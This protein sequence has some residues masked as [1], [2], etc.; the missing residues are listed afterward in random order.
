MSNNVGSLYYQVLLDGG[1]VEKGSNRIKKD[2]RELTKFLKDQS[3]KQV[4]DVDLLHKRR[5]RLLAAAR[6]L[7][8]DNAALLKE[9]ERGITKDFADQIEARNQAYIEGNRKRRE[10][11]EAE[12]TKQREDME[13]FLKAGED[14]A[15]KKLE[16]EAKSNEDV[17]K[18]KKAFLD[19]VRKNT[20][21]QAAEEKAA[22]DKL[23][24]F[25]GRSFLDYVKSHK[26]E[27]ERL[28]SVEEAYHKHRAD[29][30]RRWD[31]RRNKNAAAKRR[32]DAADFDEWSKRQ[33]RRQ[34]QFNKLMLDLHKAFEEQKKKDQ[35]DA[36]K[37]RKAREASTPLGRLQSGIDKLKGS[38]A[39]KLFFTLAGAIGSVTMAVWPL[40]Q[41]FK[42]LGRQISTVIKVVSHFVREAG[43]KKK[44]ILELTAVMGGNSRAAKELRESL[45]DYARDTAFSVEQTMEMARSLK[46]LGIATESIVPSIKKFGKLS[47]GDP[48]K[49]KLIA[50]AYTDVKALGK[51]QAK[52]VIQF[53]N[54]GVALRAELMQQL[55][56]SADQLNKAIE[57]GRVGF[58]DVDRALTSLADKF[59]NSD[60]LGLETVAGQAQAIK[61]TLDQW[62]AAI[63]TPL[64]EA[65]TDLLKDFNELLDALDDLGLATEGTGYGVFGGMIGAVKILN[66]EM[67][68]LARLM[69]INVAAKEYFFGTDE[70]FAK[71]A[72]DLQ[73][74]D[75][76]DKRAEEDA[77]ERQRQQRKA[78]IDAAELQADERR[79]KLK[80]KMR[81]YQLDE[82]EYQARLKE[83]KTGDGSDLQRIEMARKAEEEYQKLVEEGRSRAK[84]RE[85]ANRNMRLEIIQK[86]MELEEIKAERLKIESGIMGKDL[87]G[88]LPGKAF[89][90]G[91]VDEFMYEKQI[92][93]MKEADRKAAKRARE[94][95]EARAAEARKIVDAI[96]NLEMS[97][98]GNVEV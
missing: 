69:K 26:K 61:E 73:D 45:V 89:R 56:L 25:K 85:I 11:A 78:R 38:R 29:V 64:H 79:V 2:I 28:S 9:V 88:N 3:E 41:A 50:K 90:Q 18:S 60:T 58:A 33:V 13:K 21:K 66:H 24:K 75:N 36:E 53:A 54:Q 52:E 92:E 22:A 71:A 30:Q 95:N 91:S 44:Q 51:L 46:A 15:K 83:L 70:S 17:A 40:A 8:K 16:T 82:L 59:G 68:T 77:K 98:N 55:N 32:Q 27:N 1:G 31:R 20:E 87:S 74:F 43:K 67:E 84:A 7:F 62:A 96:E 34:K 81:G 6:V 72:K 94:A 48:A 37:R 47:F 14:A 63:G 80:E 10:E 57:Q 12:A 76:R 23:A 65:M 4:H 19:K 86:E 39:G 42:F 49:M 93:E 97:E 35:E 5:E